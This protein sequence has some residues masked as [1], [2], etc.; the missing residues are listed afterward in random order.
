[1]KGRVPP[2]YLKTVKPWRTGPQGMWA[3]PGRPP[4]MMARDFPLSPGPASDRVRVCPGKFARLP[5]YRRLSKEHEE[6]PETGV[7]D[8]M[9]CASISFSEVFNRRLTALC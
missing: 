1:L 7:V 2:R 4:P 3:I 9:A 5:A 6:L 8:T